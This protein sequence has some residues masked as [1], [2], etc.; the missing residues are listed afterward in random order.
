MARLRAA[1]ATHA[2]VGWVVVPRIRTRRVAC[3]MIA[4]TYS[5]APVRVEVSKKSAAMMASAWERRNGAQV[6]DVRWGAGSMPAC[7]R[8]SHTVD[9]A[10]LIP[11]T[12]SSPWMRR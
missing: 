8:I 6:C 4:S 12:S 3:S 2:A 10:T 7:L 1:W 5:L 9:A 11:S